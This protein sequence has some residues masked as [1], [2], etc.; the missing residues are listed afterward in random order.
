MNN[1]IGTLDFTSDSIWFKNAHVWMPGSKA[2]GDGRYVFDNDDFDLVLRGQPMS[3]ADVRWVMPQVPARGEGTLDFRLR[4]RGDT[5]T[6]IAQNADVRIDSTRTD[7]DFAISMVGDSLWFHDTDVQFSSVDTHLIEQLFPAVKI[8]RHGTLTGTTKLDGPPGLMRVDGDVAFDDARYGRSR[9]MAVGAVGTTGTRRSLSR[10]RP[11]ARSGAGRA[12]RARSRRPCRIGGT[13]R[14]S[15]RLNGETDTRLVVR[16]DL[17]HNDGGLRSR[18][19]GNATMRF[20][21]RP[22]FDV[23]ARLL[24]ALAGGGRQVRAGGRAHGHRG[25]PGARNR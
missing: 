10:P 13:L 16:A 19:A 18:V 24:P 5:S 25:G 7:G 15:A 21:S 9:V 2:A 11:D 22:W 23:D 4:W 6:Y 1:F 17:T 8:P 3:L 20:G 12:W 14:G